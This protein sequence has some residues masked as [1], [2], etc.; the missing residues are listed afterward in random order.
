[1]FLFSGLHTC[2]C[3]PVLHELKSM[4]ATSRTTGETLAFH[5]SFQLCSALI[6]HHIKQYEKWKTRKL[7]QIFER[8]APHSPPYLTWPSLPIW[9]INTL[10]MLS[11]DTLY[12][13]S[14][15]NFWLYLSWGA[16]STMH[17][18]GFFSRASLAG[19][20]QGFWKA[21][22]QCISSEQLPEQSKPAEEGSSRTHL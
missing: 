8:P 18:Q 1:M 20:E 15:P 13:P 16:R 9:P 11:T 12:L 3:L 4:N 17:S 19:V 22:S 5:F 7:R 21:P 14:W 10:N 6:Y 2:P